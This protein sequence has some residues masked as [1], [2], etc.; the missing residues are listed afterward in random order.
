MTLHGVDP[1]TSISYFSV[2]LGPSPLVLDSIVCF[3]YREGEE[4]HRRE[5]QTIRA[6]CSV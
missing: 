6:S 2:V 5:T 1:W 3:T 4:G